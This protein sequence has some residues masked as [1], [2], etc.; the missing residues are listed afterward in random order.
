[1]KDKVFIAWSGS[2]SVAVKVKKILEDKYNYFCTI[3]GHNFYL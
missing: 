2:N 1:M 3:G